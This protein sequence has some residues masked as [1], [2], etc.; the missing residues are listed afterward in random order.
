M[1]PLHTWSRKGFRTRYP[2]ASYCRQDWYIRAAD[3]QGAEVPWPILTDSR[4]GRRFHTRDNE[5]R[6]LGQSGRSFLLPTARHCRIADR[7]P[8]RLSAP[9][10]SR[11][12]KGG[13]R[14]AMR[15][16]TAGNHNRIRRGR[17]NPCAARCGRRAAYSLL[18]SWSK[19]LDSCGFARH[20]SAALGYAVGNEPPL[21]IRTFGH[22]KNDGRGISHSA[23]DL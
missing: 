10:P 16:D 15:D 21:R 13:P 2:K 20:F 7:L 3:V 23:Y 5:S 8:L 4:I 9:R 1:H 19:V 14:R 11:A 22:A 12:A 17:R 18:L 6:P